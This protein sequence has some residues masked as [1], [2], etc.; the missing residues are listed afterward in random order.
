LRGDPL[1]WLAQLAARH[2]KRMVGLMVIFVVVSVAVGAPVISKLTTGSQDFQDP[3]AENVTAR[4]EVERASGVDP[5][6]AMI[7]IIHTDG[8]VA[9]PAG[10]PKV[11]KV[12]RTIQQDPAVGSVSMLFNTG[13]PS[14]LSRDGKSTYAAVSFKP[15][16]AKEQAD[17]A[18]RIEKRFEGD[19]SV[20]LG[21]PAVA[22]EQ[23]NDRVTND[24]RRAELFA[25]P[26]LILL[27]LLFFRGLVAALLPIMCAVISIMGSLLL[28]R[29]V[30]E[31]TPLSIFSTNLITGLGIGLGI[32]Y[33]LFMVSRYREELVAVGPGA[34]A[35][36]RTLQTAGRTVAFSALT[37][38]AGMSALLAFPQR[39]LYSMGFG[40]VFVAL[41]AALSAVVF[42]PSVL[43]LLGTRVNALAPRR[44]QHA[45]ERTARAERAGPWYRL[46][47]FVMRRA[48]SVAIVSAALMITIGLP[49]SHLRFTGVDATVLPT[50]ASAH[51]VQTQI[52]TEF[53][54]NNA[55]PIY[56][57]ASA[58]KS[59]APQV[60][61]FTDG[62]ASLPGLI[63]ISAPDYLGSDTWRIDVISQTSDLAG[64][65]Q[66][67]VRD[68]RAAP[69]SF[70]VR[71][72]GETAAYV[73][74]QH[75]VLTRLPIALVIASLT[76]L[77]LLFLM[78]GSVVL[79]IKAVLMNV[80][81][82][83]ATLGALVFV[84]EDGHLA[85]LFDFTSQGA[86]NSSQPILIGAIAF[87]LS[88]DY[89]VFLLTRIKEARSEVGNDEEAVAVGMERT[90]RIVTAAA[91]L[92]AIAMGAFVTSQIVVIKQLG[93]GVAFAV[94]IDAAIVR[95]LL[96][97]ALMRL[98]GRWNWWAPAALRRVH[99][100][101][102]LREAHEP[103]PS[104]PAVGPE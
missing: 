9:S 26:F 51:Q 40:G 88:T 65:S 7:V 48:G 28:L 83:V 54:E 13:N 64:A 84:F 63:T 86:L 42:L 23:V 32:D 39:F 12:V 101:I 67:L 44:W 76:T 92:L 96:V 29:F 80:L 8:L 30:H 24:L 91:L 55:S 41:V 100:R 34:E 74:Q 79:P 38:A 4:H 15:L 53:A 87:A 66:D 27:S 5:A 35:L 2:P 16:S 94:L 102:G 69:A 11:L 6:I 77:I 17:A 20:L 85:G 22:T 98:L 99:E 52:E 45:V 90:G 68:I 70:P 46:S 104:R 33:S 10:I 97:P 78:T 72:G 95:A 58:P 43:A 37:V 18:K 73:D 60:Q 49:F 31:L 71:V 62:L 47:Q 93:F 89:A 25:A 81:T 50:S 21:G 1:T 61:S 14:F 36:R 3:N 56:V 75:S 19:S 59:A 103:A 57:A 82:I